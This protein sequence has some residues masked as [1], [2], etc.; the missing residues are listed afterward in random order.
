MAK[1]KQSER[2]TRNAGAPAPEVEGKK[3]GGSSKLPWLIIIG[4]VVASLWAIGAL[5][6][7]GVVP[8]VFIF[9]YLDFYAASW[10]WSRC[11]SPSWWAWRP[12]TG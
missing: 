3:K 8:A 11:R 5:T 7:A 6:T 4:G 2:P 1:R 12:R 9:A 10:C